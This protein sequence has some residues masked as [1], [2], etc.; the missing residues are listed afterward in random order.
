MM[1]AAEAAGVADEVLASLDASERPRPWPERAAYNLERMTTHG[2]RRA[3]E[4]EEAVRTLTA[5][6]V[7]PVMTEGTVHRQREMA[8]PQDERTFA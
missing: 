8:G 1:L 3:A 2:L 5:L 7:A 6:G 4:M